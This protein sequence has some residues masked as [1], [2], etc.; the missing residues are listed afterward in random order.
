MADLQRHGIVFPK[1]ESPCSSSTTLYRCIPSNEEEEREQLNMMLKQSMLDQQQLSCYSATAPPFSTR[2]P[3]P[4][5]VNAPVIDA[6]ITVS[7]KEEIFVQD[8]DE[9]T[10]SDPQPE[11]N[12]VER[13]TAAEVL[14]SLMGLKKTLK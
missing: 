13:E 9:S 8:S 12:D 2:Q 7:S 1:H 10:I 3:D 6:R 5:P 14:V 4:K 11:N